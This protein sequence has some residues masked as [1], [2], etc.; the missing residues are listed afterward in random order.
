MGKI[1]DKFSIL[2]TNKDLRPYDRPSLLRKNCLFTLTRPFHYLF[3][4]PLADGTVPSFWK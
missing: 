1:L 2:G 4:Q 3:N